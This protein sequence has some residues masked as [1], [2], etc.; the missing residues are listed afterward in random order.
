MEDYDDNE[1]GA[2]NNV[3]VTGDCGFNDPLI[4]SI[5]NDLIKDDDNNR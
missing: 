1:I 2:L 5:T 3:E 4:N